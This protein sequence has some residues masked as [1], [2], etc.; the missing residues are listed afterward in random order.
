VRS[1]P[2]R[3]RTGPGPMR[4]I[5]SEYVI[6]NASGIAMTNARAMPAVAIA[7]VSSVAFSS[8]PRKSLDVAGGTKPARKLAITRALP[9]SNKTQ[10]L[11][12]GRA[13]SRERG[14]MMGVV[15]SDEIRE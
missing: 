12:I 7:S 2:P 9:A 11:K 5:D 15:G 4:E 13:S 3:Q 1:A 6:A 8:R 10:G 14:W